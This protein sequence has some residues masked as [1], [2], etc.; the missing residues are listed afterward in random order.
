MLTIFGSRAQSILPPA[1]PWH[2]KSEALV[3]QPGNPWITPAERNNF[4][5]TPDYA[6][7][8]RWCRKLAASS[9]LLHVV[10][11]GRSVEG[12]EIVMVVASAE[13]ITSAEAL[14]KSGKLLLLAQAGIH[15]GQRCN[16]RH[17]RLCLCAKQHHKSQHG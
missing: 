5:L 2:G 4:R 8:L 13:K 15:A 3:A 17:G 6:A 14:R 12:R 16:P 10:T 7:T 9:P 11:I 1:L